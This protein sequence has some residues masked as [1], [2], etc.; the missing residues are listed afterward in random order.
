MANT[1]SPSSLGIQAPSGGFQQ[2]GWYNGRQYWGGTLSDPGVIHPQ[3]N[4]VGAGNLVSAEVNLQSDAA[5]GNNPGDIERYLAQQR[6]AQPSAAMPVAQTGFSGSGQTGSYGA[7]TGVGAG[8]AV[9]PTQT[10]F[11][12]PELYKSLTEGSDIKAKQSQLAELEKQFTETKGKIN[13]NPYLSEAT[14]V[15]KVAKLEQLHAERTANLRDE[16]ATTQADIETQLNLQT[17]QFDIDSQLARDA[18]DQLSFLL[19]SGALDN[20]SGEDIATLTRATGISSNMIYSAI[21]AN[22]KKNV[23]T[24]IIK[25]EDDNGVVTITVIDSNSGNIISQQSLGAIGNK[26]GSGSSGASTS[27][28]QDRVVEDA[29][30]LNGFADDSGKWWGIFP[31]LVAIYANQLSLQEIY[32]AYASAGYPTPIESAEEIQAIYDEAKGL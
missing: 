30:V 16:I 27:S 23:Q 28:I 22:K 13:D 18:R 19:D 29:Q 31:Q 24:E 11:N 5:Q 1:Y 6:Q 4:Q 26:Q 32:R 12:L 2:G 25:S 21:E 3:S 14:R 8:L 20:A 17:K 15:G 7:G 10:Q 9:A